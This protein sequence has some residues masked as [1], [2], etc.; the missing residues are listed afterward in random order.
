MIVHSPYRHVV[1]HTHILLCPP[2]IQ[3]LLDDL[4]ELRDREIIEVE[5]SQLITWLTSFF[6]P[7]G[8]QTF[9]PIKKSTIGASTWLLVSYKDIKSEVILA[10]IRDLMHLHGNTH[11]EYQDN[12]KIYA[13]LNDLLRRACKRM[14][15][16]PSRKRRR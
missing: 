3:S 4:R 6:M 13:I 16:K 2:D 7:H 10:L 15:S 8:K 11:R 14:Q 1:I 12:K 5:S 9:T